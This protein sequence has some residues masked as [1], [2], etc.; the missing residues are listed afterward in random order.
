MTRWKNKN[1]GLIY[2]YMGYGVNI[3][4]GIETNIVIYSKENRT[5]KIF[6]MEENEFFNLHTDMGELIPRVD[7]I[8]KGGRW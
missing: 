5:N 3:C 1:T 8:S 6:T 2:I 4:K 7:M